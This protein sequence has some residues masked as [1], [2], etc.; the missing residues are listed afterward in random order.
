MPAETPLGP[1]IELLVLALTGVAAWRL[2]R[3]LRPPP[4]RVMLLAGAGLLVLAVASAGVSIWTSHNPGVRL[5]PAPWQRPHPGIR[6]LLEA[7][8][9][10]GFEPVGPPRRADDPARMVL[11]GQVHRTLP[12]YAT[13]FDADSPYGGRT[14]CDLI[15][16]LAD[17]RGVLITAGEVWEGVMPPYPGEFRQILPGA[18]PADLLAAHL[19]ALEF[20]SPRGFTPRTLSTASWEPDLR[21]VEGRRRRQFLRWPL[22]TSALV[23]WRSLRGGTPYL[24]PLAAQ[25]SVAGQL[26]RA[27]GPVSR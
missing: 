14:A 19:V 15:S 24:G 9:E 3:R 1:V 10:L 18:G 4:V 26:R 27:L 11:W 2:T 21:S 16:L 6:R 8:A 13:V 12:V 22:T 5:E 23:I 7:V 25:P 20:L 17:D